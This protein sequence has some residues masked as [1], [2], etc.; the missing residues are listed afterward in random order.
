MSSIGIVNEILGRPVVRARSIVTAEG[1]YLLLQDLLASLRDDPMMELCDV[2]G[3]TGQ[4]V[5]DQRRKSIA[6]YLMVKAGEARVRGKTAS[7]TE[8]ETETPQN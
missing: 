1:K 2:V 8:A 4:G 3:Q 7:E 6:F 5:A